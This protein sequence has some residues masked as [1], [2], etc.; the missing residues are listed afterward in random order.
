MKHSSHQRVFSWV[1]VRNASVVALSAAA[2]VLS[3]CGGSSS[4]DGP[5]EA[6]IDTLV[7]QIGGA[8]QDVELYNDGTTDWTLYTM[9]NRFAATPV[10][11]TK[12]A[13]TEITVPGYIQHITVVK[14][15]GPADAKKC[16]W[17]AKA[18]A[19]STSPIRRPWS[20]CAP[21]R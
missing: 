20:T 10:G 18:S 1:S 13:V 19:W 14:D 6:N 15:Y 11:M 4:S 17:V 16:R 7:A 3:G 8:T 5:I 2:L 21:W 12:G 9:A